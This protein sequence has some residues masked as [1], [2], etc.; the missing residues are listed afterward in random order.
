MARDEAAALAEYGA[1]FRADVETFV[2][3]EAVQA[4]ISAGVRERGAERASEYF[5]FVDPSG[6]SSDSMTVA[7]GH[8][9]GDGKTLHHGC[10]TR[11]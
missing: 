4:C 1:Q 5:A 2:S 11:A 10:S 7:I 3:M 9:A 8:A 6:G